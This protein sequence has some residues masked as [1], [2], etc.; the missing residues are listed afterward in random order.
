MTSRPRPRNWWIAPGV[1]LLLVAG[2]W[3]ERRLFHQP[4][5]DPASYHAMIRAVADRLSYRIGDWEGVDEEPAPAAVAMLKPNLLLQ[6]RFENAV[7]GE[8]A[9]LMIAQCRDARDMGSHYPPVCYRM[10]GWTER[11]TASRTIRVK[12]TD[13]PVTVYRFTKDSF[14][15]YDEIVIYNFFVRPDGSIE[16]GR[17]GVAEAASNP[18][19]KLFGA[20]Q[21]QVL[22]GPPLPG[23]RMDEVFQTIVANAFPVLDAIREGSVQ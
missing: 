2:I 22:F 12:E 21:V 16:S 18:R 5:G 9:T 15:Q 10:Q 23:D 20:G 19:M 13:I 7:T 11:G 4:V 17:A 14:D 3:L 6:R 1:C 8:R